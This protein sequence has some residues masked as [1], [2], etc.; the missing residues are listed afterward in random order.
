MFSLIE[1]AVFFMALL[2]ILSGSIEVLAALVMLRFNDIE[3]SFI[4]NSSLAFI[5]PLIL[6]T[7]TAIGVVGMSS[8]LSF[9]KVFWIFLGVALIIYGVKKG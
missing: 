4:I 1:K 6:L 5:G 8:K 7:T 3:K 9:G 2:R